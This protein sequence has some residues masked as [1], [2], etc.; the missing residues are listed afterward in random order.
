MGGLGGGNT[1]NKHTKYTYNTHTYQAEVINL[2]GSGG[3]WEELEWER[4]VKMI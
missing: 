4:E 3:T 1:L 2:R